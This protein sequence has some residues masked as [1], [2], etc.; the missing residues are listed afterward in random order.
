MAI[1][2]QRPPEDIPRLGCDFNA[3]G[4]SSE[5]RSRAIGALK[6][7]EGMRVVIHEPDLGEQGEPQVF[8]CIATLEFHRGKASSERAP[9]Q[10]RST[11]ISSRRLNL[12]VVWP[13]NE[14]I[15]L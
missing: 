1:E 9:Y 2:G 8:G 6:L 15:G 3:A 13:R 10:A 4:W 5:S 11:V 7:T 14:Q 12:V